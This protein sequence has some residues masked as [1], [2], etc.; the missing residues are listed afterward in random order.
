MSNEAWRKH[1]SKFAKWWQVPG[2]HNTVY[3]Q[4]WLSEIRSHSKKSVFP[5]WDIIGQRAMW[6]KSEGY[7]KAQERR[8]GRDAEYQRQRRKDPRVKAAHAR[9]VRLKQQAN[10]QNRMRRNLSRR[11][12]EIMNGAKASRTVIEFV[13]C[14]EAKLRE[15][16]EAQ[17]APWMNWENYG[18]AWHVDHIVPVSAFDHSDPKQVKTCWN[19]ANLRPL[20]AEENT[21]KKDKITHPQMPLTLI[22]D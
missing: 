9:R 14:S 18:T 1:R 17:F 4:Y 11:L 6:M 3:S 7:A 5:D 22:F 16:I 21:V 2:T 8:K 15:H 12:C 20:K 10:P 19:W 13:G